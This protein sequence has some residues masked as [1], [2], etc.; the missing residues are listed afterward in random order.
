MLS[1][2]SVWQSL[3]IP[4]EAL[5]YDW[6]LSTSLTNLVRSYALYRLLLTGTLEVLGLP[7]HI[8]G[9]ALTLWLAVTRDR[10]VSFVMRTY[11]YDD[12]GYREI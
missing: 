9:D 7:W 12:T 2:L 5:R 1:S 3:A 6:G 8:G 4:G 10:T 11:N